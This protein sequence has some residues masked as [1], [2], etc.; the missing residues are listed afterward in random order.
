METGFAEAS[1][2]DASSAVSCSR[3]AHPPS[4]SDIVTFARPDGEPAAGAGEDTALEAEAARAS[5]HTDDAV[6]HTE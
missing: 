1:D 5:R 3:S 6:F 2:D 4:T